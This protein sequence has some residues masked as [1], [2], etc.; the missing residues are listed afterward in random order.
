MV[1][2]RWKMRGLSRRKG[3]GVWQGRF[4]IPSE[5]WNERDRLIELGVKVGKNQDF[6][7]SLGERTKSVAERVYMDRLRTIKERWPNGRRC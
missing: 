1:G 2:R 4:Y 6:L 3:S 5:I 7:K